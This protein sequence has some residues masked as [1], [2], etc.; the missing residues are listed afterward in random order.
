MPTQQ[1]PQ[2][3][4]SSSAAVGAGGS[5]QDGMGPTPGSRP[6]THQ[7]KVSGTVF[8][9]EKRYDLIRPIGTGA[10]GVVM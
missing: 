1:Q 3:A 10:Y 8:E 5:P 7:F 2:Q 9:V 6:G 4:A